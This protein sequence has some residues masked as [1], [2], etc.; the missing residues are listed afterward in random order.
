MRLNSQQGSTQMKPI[1]MTLF[2]VFGATGVASAQSGICEI[3]AQ[4]A[5]TKETAKR[6]LSKTRILKTQTVTDTAEYLVTVGTN[7]GN[8]THLV[9][10]SLS[11]QGTTCLALKTPLLV[12]V[13]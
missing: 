2:F 10:T 13:N 5:A 8:D 6:T 3:A 4:V 7:A 9:R 1:F 11:P 12:E